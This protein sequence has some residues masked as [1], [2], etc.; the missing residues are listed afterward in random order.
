[1]GAN[2]KLSFLNKILISL[3]IFYS[4]LSIGYSSI[5]TQ[6]FALDYDS[7]IF[8]YR[9]IAKEGI[10]GVCSNDHR[11]TR[12][13]IPLAAHGL[14][15]INPLEGKFNS[16]RFNIFVINIVIFYITVISLFW[17]TSKRYNLEIA[18][19]TIVFFFTH[20]IF[21]SLYLG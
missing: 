12:I 7:D 14:S 16:P 1:M 11:C 13:A 2:L 6:N 5:D 8:I 20:F 10:E 15:K 18:I 17:L 4:G 21:S 3:L 9:N 19:L